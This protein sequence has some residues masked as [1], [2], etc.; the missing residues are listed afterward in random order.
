MALAFFFIRSPMALAFFFIRNPFL[1]RERPSEVG[2][3]TWWEE[4]EK[5]FGELSHCVFFGLY[6]KKETKKLMLSNWLNH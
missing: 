2:I 5:R 4:S 3:T 6:G 1:F